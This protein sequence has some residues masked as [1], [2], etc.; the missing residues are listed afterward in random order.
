MDMY[1][2]WTCT[3]YGHVPYMDMYRIWT[4]TL[5]GHV[6]SVSVDMYH[7]DYH[8]YINASGSVVRESEWCFE[9]LHSNP[10]KFC[11]LKHLQCLRSPLF[12]SPL[13]PFPLPSSLLTLFSL[14]LSLPLPPPTSAYDPAEFEHLPVSSELKELFQHITRYTPQTVDLETKLKPFI[15]EYIPAIGD[16][17]AFLKVGGTGWVVHDV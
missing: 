3:I 15:P 11:L 5:Y 17:D 7:D 16:I 2:I 14:S 6:L 13:L 4:C 10:C 12:H 9:D 8:V 1:H